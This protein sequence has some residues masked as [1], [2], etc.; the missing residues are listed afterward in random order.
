MGMMKNLAQK[1]A[2]Y[3]ISVNDVAPALIEETGMLPNADAIPG[4]AGSI[5]LGRMVSLS[6][7]LAVFFSFHSTRVVVEFGMEVTC[8]KEGV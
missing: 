2:P 1:L 6:S 5:P 7:S 8:G 4:G 3:N